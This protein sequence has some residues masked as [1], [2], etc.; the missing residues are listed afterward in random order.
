M[1]AHAI[2]CMFHIYTYTGATCCVVCFLI[3][4]VSFVC[5][6]QEWNVDE[7]EDDDDDDDEGLA[8]TPV[9]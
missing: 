5:A 9:L 8:V 6:F 4:L 7:D 1:N 3:L 2:H